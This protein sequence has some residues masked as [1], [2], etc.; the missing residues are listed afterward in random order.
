MNAVAIRRY[1]TRPS[2]HTSSR[3]LVGTVIEAAEDVDVGD[4][5]EEA[6]AV[7]VDVAER[8]S[9]IHVAH[10]V[11]DGIE[12]PVGTRIIPHRE[13]DAGD[14]LDRQ[15]QAGEDTEVPPVIEVARNRIAAA[16][17]A[18][19]QRGSGRRSSSQRMRPDFGS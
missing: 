10:D 17:R 19:D 9:R 15:E 6:G 2:I 7:H 3:G 11:L 5:E 8:P 18:V 1:M 4:D 14:D 13:H 16:D 12:G